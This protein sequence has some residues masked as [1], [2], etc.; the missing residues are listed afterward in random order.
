MKVT[1]DGISCE[2]PSC[3]PRDKYTKN[4]KCSLC[5]PYTVPDVKRFNCVKPVCKDREKILKDGSCELCR[6]YTIVT[7]N[8]IGCEQV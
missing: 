6:P 5:P 1:K 4:G 2:Y 3:E 8:E 7:E